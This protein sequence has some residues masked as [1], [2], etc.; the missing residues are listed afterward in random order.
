MRIFF[1]CLF[2]I[3]IIGF[4]MIFP[5]P[6]NFS[7]SEIKTV[8]AQEEKFVLVKRKRQGSIVAL[9]VKVSG[10]VDG[11]AIISESY[12]RNGGFRADTVEGEF[13]LEYGGDWYQDTCYFLYMPL[14]AKHG[15][16]EFRYRFNGMNNF[17]GFD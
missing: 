12:I 10:F 5:E 2:V 16:I 14:T 6:V 11:K 9:K 13:K 17:W 3:I 7:R 4:L 8:S 15:T 1:F